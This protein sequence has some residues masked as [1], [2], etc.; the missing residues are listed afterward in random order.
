[1]YNIN[2]ERIYNYVYEWQFTVPMWV[3]TVNVIT[4]SQM[5][6]FI[7]GV[8]H[9]IHYHMLVLCSYNSQYVFVYVCVSTHDLICMHTD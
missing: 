1:M 7:T 8:G 5:A 4:V 3:F 9:I 6:L 2:I